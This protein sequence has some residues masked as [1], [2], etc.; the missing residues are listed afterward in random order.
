M[1]KKKGCDYEMSMHIG[2][3]VWS[4]PPLQG[5]AD[6]R[7]QPGNMFEDTFDEHI[8]ALSEVRATKNSSSAPFDEKRN[9]ADTWNRNDASKN[10]AT[11]KKEV[12]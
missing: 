1:K 9:A 12:R 8:A 4:T 7:A 3:A 2:Q 10:L 5:A 11:I 6:A